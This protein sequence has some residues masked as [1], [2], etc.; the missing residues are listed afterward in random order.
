VINDDHDDGER[1]QKIE[2]GLAFAISKARIDFHF[3]TV[4]LRP[5]AHQ[6]YFGNWAENLSVICASDKKKLKVN[7][8]KC[9]SSSITFFAASYGAP[10]AAYGAEED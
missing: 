4:R 5:N 2:A 9:T 7:R 8:R 1:T 10:R 3:A 6:S